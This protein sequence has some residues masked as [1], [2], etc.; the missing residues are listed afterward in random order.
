MDGIQVME[1]EDERE[2]G[3]KVAEATSEAGRQTLG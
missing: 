3:R 1:I 2:G